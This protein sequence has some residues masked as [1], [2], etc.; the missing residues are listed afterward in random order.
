M[1]AL[2]G[3]GFAHLPGAIDAHVLAGLAEIAT[4]IPSDAGGRRWAGVELARLLANPILDSLRR[5]LLPEACVLRIVAF[6]KD[7]AANWFVPAHQDRSVPIPSAVPPPGFTRPT[8][9]GNGW[10]A[11]A[12]IAL[13]KSMR[14]VRIFIDPATQDDGPLEVAPGTHRLGRIEQS[15]IPAVAGEAEWHPLTGNAGDLVILSPLLLHRS[16][17]ARAP[18]GRRVLQLECVAGDVAGRFGLI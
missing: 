3:A 7:A 2:D 14:N 12:P 4:G 15:A 11:E 8:R 10:Q 17:R 5:T 9:K 18:R 13:L 1:P 6:K 16:S